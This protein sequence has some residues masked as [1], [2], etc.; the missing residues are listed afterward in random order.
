M[1]YKIINRTNSTNR[2]SRLNKE[3]KRYK[4]YL[5]IVTNRSNKLIAN[6]QEKSKAKRV[7]GG[8]NNA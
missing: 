8:T 6:L 1:P 3:L 5:S 7:R 4:D 2:K